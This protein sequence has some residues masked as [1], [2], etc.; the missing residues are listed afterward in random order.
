MFRKYQI[1]GVVSAP[2]LCL[3]LLTGCSLPGGRMG[4]VQNTLSGAKSAL[5]SPTAHPHDPSVDPVVIESPTPVPGASANAQQLGLSDRTIV[6]ESVSE[7]ADST[8][9]FATITLQ[10]TF[11][12]TGDKDIDNLAAAYKLVGTEGDMFGLQPG[13]SDYFGRVA[14]GSVRSGVVAFQQIPSAATRKLQL[15]YHAD[16]S[17]VVFAPLS[18]G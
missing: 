4:N 5:A 12:D 6:I 13:S 15:Y 10:L 7:Q 9:D 14:A 18:I 3:F 8:D 11:K 1:I 16:A 17:Q 2:L